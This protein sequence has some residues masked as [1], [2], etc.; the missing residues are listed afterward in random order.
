MG[1]NVF[2]CPRTQRDP[3]RTFVQ[4]KGS[5]FELSPTATDFANRPELP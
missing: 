5:Q 3:F 4:V 1:A 2:R